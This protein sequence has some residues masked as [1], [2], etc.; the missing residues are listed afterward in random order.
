MKAVRSRA[1]LHRRGQAPA[2]P[3]HSAKSVLGLSGLVVLSWMI[4]VTI[5]L[6]AL[7]GK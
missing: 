1:E 2:L 5:A 7:Y 3:W 6:L 4:G